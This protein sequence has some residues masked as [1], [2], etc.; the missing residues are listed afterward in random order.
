MPFEAYVDQVRKDRRL[1]RLSHE[2]ICDSIVDAGVSIDLRGQ[3]HYDLWKDELFG[4]DSAIT[5]VVEY[6]A[7]SARRLEVRKRILLLIGP[8]GCGKSTLVNT[9]KEGLEHYTRAAAGAVWAIKGC[10]VYENPLHLIPRQRRGQLRSIYVEGELCPY[11]GWIVRN[12]YK[13]DVTRV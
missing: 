7:A 9:I 8:P 5:Q 1:A 3:R 11:C 13:N 12:V 10:P 6:F 4:A 2:L